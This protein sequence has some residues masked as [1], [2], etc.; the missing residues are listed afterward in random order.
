MLHR[1]SAC[2]LRSAWFS[3]REQERFSEN[4]IHAF[5][6]TLYPRG[7]IVLKGEYIFSDANGVN[8]ISGGRLELN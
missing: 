1:G 5:S 3:E 4:L 2:S 6:L 7:K 8:R